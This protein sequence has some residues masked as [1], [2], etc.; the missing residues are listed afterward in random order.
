MTPESLTY[1]CPACGG[2]LHYD[3][4]TGQPSCEYCGSAFTVEQVEA[5][6]AQQQ[7]KADADNMKFKHDN[8]QQTAAETKAKVNE[9][10]ESLKK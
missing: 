5:F 2:P 6:Y 7:A 4:Q 8:A 3:A 10:R 9:I 1:Q